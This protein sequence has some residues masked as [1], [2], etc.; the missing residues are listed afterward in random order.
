MLTITMPV[1]LA[2]DSTVNIG[3]CEQ[4]NEGGGHSGDA[5]EHLADG[6]ALRSPDPRIC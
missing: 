6:P 4:R 3:E 2:A 5:D 1:P